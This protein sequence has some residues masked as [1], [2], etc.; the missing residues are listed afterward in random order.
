MSFQDEF[1]AYNRDS[2]T[3]A[4]TPLVA[5]L[6]L[7]GNFSYRDIVREDLLRI[8][9]EHSIPGGWLFKRNPGSV[10]SW[11]RRFALLRGSYMF[12]FHSPMNE[13]PIC[14]IPLQG[15]D[16]I[17]PSDGEKTFDDQR[18]SK[19]VDGFEWEF[20]RNDSSSN[21]RFYSLSEEERDQWIEATAERSRR[22]D[23]IP[24]SFL[25]IS[26]K[27]QTIFRNNL[28]ITSSRLEGPSFTGA[29]EGQGEWSRQ[30][31]ITNNPFYPSLNV[32]DQENPVHELSQDFDDSRIDEQLGVVDEE[33]PAV[34]SS[35][36]DH[37]D[38]IYDEYIPD[39]DDPQHQQYDKRMEGRDP[40]QVMKKGYGN[41]YDE[42]EDCGI[43]E[44]E[45]AQMQRIQAEGRRREVAA[46]ERYVLIL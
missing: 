4:L 13:K 14:V 10:S 6:R 2:S 27:S 15:I 20:H 26:G 28:T 1:L 17:A 5:V 25:Q 40:H 31:S 44:Q 8:V 32:S 29:R 41:E 3:G 33:Y 39:D 43:N 36:F 23:D 46:R 38:H 24:E 45:Q 30:N 22:V 18:G 7:D 9:D 12:L 34:E 37:Q 16:V 11:I 19:P 35:L 42:E 21:T